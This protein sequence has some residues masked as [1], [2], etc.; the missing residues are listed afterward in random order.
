MTMSLPGR[1]ASLARRDALTAVG[2]ALSAGWLIL[3]MLFW[4][5]APGDE[6][7]TGGVTRL[8]AI[9]GAVMPLALIWM[10]VSLARS[11]AELRAEADHLHR[12][13]DELRGGKPARPTRSE[14]QPR[15]SGTARPAP[16]PDRSPPAPRPQVPAQPRPAA[17]ARPDPRQSA[18]SFDAPEAVDIPAETVIRALNF[19]DGPDDADAIAALRSALQDHETARVLRAAQD[20]ITLLADRGVYMDDLPP[21]PAPADVW[22]RFGEGERGSAIAPLGGINDADA[23]ALTSDILRGDEIFRDSAHHFLRHFDVLITQLIPQLDDAEL[24]VMGDTRST[25]AFMLVGRAAGLFA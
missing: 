3:L 8:V 9:I 19:P 2:Y 24:Q 17:I 15:P 20:V 23:L 11:I 22:R 25:R 10:A 21:Q 16:P 5:L 1:L 14:D 18:M 6:G 12:Q 4:L 13:L 7:A